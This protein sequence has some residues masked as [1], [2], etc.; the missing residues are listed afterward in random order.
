VVRLPNARPRPTK[1]SHQQILAPLTFTV[2]SLLQILSSHFEPNFSDRRLATTNNG[3]RDCGVRLASL[4]Y[5]QRAPASDTLRDT[6]RGAG[7]MNSYAHGAAT[8]LVS[9]S[10][11]PSATAP[12]PPAPHADQAPRRAHRRSRRRTQARTS[13]IAVTPDVG[14][15]PHAATPRTPSSV[16]VRSTL[17]FCEHRMFSR[18]P[19]A[20]SL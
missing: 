18:Q 4:R 19:R 16:C 14:C 15:P 10:N 11:T 20:Q 3:G 2:R 8:H 6:R 17:H 13:S 7:S 12:E 1:A 5:P 9:R